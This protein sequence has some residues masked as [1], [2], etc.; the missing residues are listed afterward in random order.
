MSEGRWRITVTAPDWGEDHLTLDAIVAFVDDLPELTGL[1][2]T[3][4]DRRVDVTIDHEDINL[5]DVALLV[6]LLR[7]TEALMDADDVTVVVVSSANPDFF[8]A[9]FDITEVFPGFG[10]IQNLPFYGPDN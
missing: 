3:Q 6:S 9:H 5:L 7:L 1:R 8:I 4:R 2:V 10:T